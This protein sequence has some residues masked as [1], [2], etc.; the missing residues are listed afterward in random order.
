MAKIVIAGASGLIGGALVD[1][2]HARGEEVVRLV[3]RAPSGP[4]EVRWSPGD[5]D[6][7]PAV[8]D[9]AAAVITL[10]GASISKLPWTRSYRATL[11]TSRITPTLALGRAVRR[12]GTDA[13]AFL[14]ASASGYYGNRPGAEL[15]ES[16]SA[17]TSFLARL[18][19]SWESA[20]RESAG[21]H[22]RIVHLR[23]ASVVHPKAVLRPLIVLAKAGVAGPLAGGHQY[24][25]WTSLE[26]EVG[27]ILHSLDH[28]ITGPVNLA[29]PEPATANELVGAVAHR[30]HR[31]YLVPV[32]A[33]ALRTVLGRDAAE[34]L[35]LADARVR[36]K[37]LDD[38][39]YAFRVR[40]VAEAVDR[41]LGADAGAQR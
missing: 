22:A 17:G 4:D 16:A 14:A 20:A 30:L 11:V 40:T 38:T 26:D 9:G 15:D 8:L 39:G 34:G 5:E 13:P 10:N 32:P 12:L 33:F 23:T 21:P 18:C 6:L 28:D 27:G 3:R 36:P 19:A 35:L 1:A 2:L 24:W 25:P 37:V 31:P 7:D 41:A 29:G